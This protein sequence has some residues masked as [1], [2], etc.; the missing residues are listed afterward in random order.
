MLVCVLGI[1][2]CTDVWRRQVGPD[3]PGSDPLQRVDG[4]VVGV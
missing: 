4:P 3:P 1:V 2:A